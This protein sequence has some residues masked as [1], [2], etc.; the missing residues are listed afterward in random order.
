MLNSEIVGK[1]VA[2][3]KSTKVSKKPKESGCCSGNDNNDSCC[4][5]NPNE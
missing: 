2:E 1:N 3:V 4:S 5:T